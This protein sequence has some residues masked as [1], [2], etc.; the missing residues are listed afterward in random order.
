MLR[1][2]NDG[3]WTTTDESLIICDICHV[4]KYPFAS[5]K[6]RHSSKTVLAD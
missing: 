5:K 4:T 2:E 3:V 6:K 1:V